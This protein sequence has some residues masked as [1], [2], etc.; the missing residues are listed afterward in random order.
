MLINDLQQVTWSYQVSAPIVDH[1][2]PDS[3]WT[4]VRRRS[5]RSIALPPISLPRTHPQQPPFLFCLS[6]DLFLLLLYLSELSPYPARNA[7][8]CFLSSP[9]YLF[10]LSILFLLFRIFW[11]IFHSSYILDSLALCDVPNVKRW[12]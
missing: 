8:L 11:L 4:L 2:R 7:E 3:A 10:I 9:H 1:I 12:I 5:K 6:R